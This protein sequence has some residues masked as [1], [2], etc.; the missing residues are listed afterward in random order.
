MIRIAWVGQYRIADSTAGRWSASGRSCNTR[1]FNSS[2]SRAKTSGASLV[3]TPA[4][5]T[6]ELI[7]VRGKHLWNS[8]G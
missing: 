6:L 5:G 4:R 1:T 7:N 8:A 2:P 3:H